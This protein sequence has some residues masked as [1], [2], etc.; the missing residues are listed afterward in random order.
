MSTCTCTTDQES[1]VPVFCLTYIFP[2]VYPRSASK[3]NAAGYHCKKRKY[4]IHIRR[5][6]D[7]FPLHADN[8]QTYF[9]A[10]LVP[11]RPSWY[12]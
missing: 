4:Q 1:R 11:G 8:M 5:T 10:G 2:N 9:S 6:P 12:W 3:V 7:R